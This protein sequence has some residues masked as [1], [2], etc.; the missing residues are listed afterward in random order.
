MT[1]STIRTYRGCNI[2]PVTRATTWGARWETYVSGRFIAADTL[3][4][5][6]EAIRHELG[7]NQ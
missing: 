4:G 6:R 2:Y 7:A 3:A 1:T 5:I